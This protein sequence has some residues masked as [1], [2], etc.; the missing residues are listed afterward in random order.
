M[1]AAAPAGTSAP[2]IVA[3]LLGSRAFGLAARVL[4]TLPFWWSGL[5]K[6]T[7]LP[8]AIA[9]TRGLGLH[10]A[11]AFAGATIATQ[12][13][14]SAGVIAGRWRWL[15]AGALGVFTAVATLLA[16]RFWTAPDPAARFREL[17]VCLEHAGLIGGFMLA[18][19]GGKPAP[20]RRRRT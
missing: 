4:L 20:H 2:P 9:E 18:A 14:G 12:L 8:G 3:S 5:A 15:A 7:D 16:H 10:P 6:L 17:N 19:L 13:V 1:R 11:A